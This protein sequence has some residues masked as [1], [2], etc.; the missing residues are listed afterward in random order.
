MSAKKR[1][2]VARF[3]YEGNAFCL[4]AATA[5][6]FERREWLR[7]QQAIEASRDRPTELAAVADFQ[8]KYADQ[9]ET[10][11]SRC[12]SA[13]PSGPIEHA[14]FE[15]FE[16]EVLSDLAGQRW[17]AIFLSLHGASI[18]DQ[19][20][21]TELRLV[22]AIRAQHPGVPIGASFDL[23]ANIS[24]ELPPLLAIS[25]T[26]RTHPHLDM[27]ETA[28][29]CLEHLRQVVEGEIAP[30][31]AFR[32]SGEWLQSANMRTD[33]GPMA[34]MEKMAVDLIK[35]PILDIALQGGFPYSNS[36]NNGA[37]VWVWADGDVTA[38]N[39]VLEQ[40]FLAF[41]AR[42]DDF[43]PTLIAPQDGIRQALETPGLVAVTDPAD[44][45]LSGGIG[46][47]PELLRALVESE[48][49][50]PTVFASMADPDLVSAARQA[51]IGSTIKVKLGG[52]LTPDYGQPVE[53]SVKVVRF[54]AG[55][56]VNV[57]PAQ[58]GLTVQ[59]GPT[60]V[61]RSGHIDIIVTTHVASCDDPGFF[62]LHDIDM[63]HTRL[64]CVKAKNH[65]RA[66]FTQICT[67]IVDV[68]SPGPAMLDLIALKAMANQAT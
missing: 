40:V 4:N 11:T 68:N 6:D 57:G 10:V 22:R 29:R 37:S 27:R 20:R 49:A 53:L 61:L 5:D 3:W 18:T 26:Y 32:N 47:T 9:W 34:D 12:A 62:A 35:Y 17:D 50:V 25:A 31:A 36:P 60:A 23:H 16:S 55:E 19:D 59:C 51:G 8:D 33:A 42:F 52:R 56:F 24:P 15:R 38:A 43:L 14:F 54:T 66:A 45:P 13:L 67:R 64:L 39:Q 46:D 2:A 65:F 28:A 30:V 44:N 58:T 1:L 7:G 41:E 63:A 48:L 21:S